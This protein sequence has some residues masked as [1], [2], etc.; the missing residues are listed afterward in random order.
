[1]IFYSILFILVIKMYILKEE[2]TVYAT[3]DN[4][5]YLYADGQLVAES[6]D[7]ESTQTAQLQHRPRVL[8]MK[9]ID[10]GGAA[11]ILLSANNGLGHR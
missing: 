10:W 4:E 11:G 1:L 7:W 3:C 6:A 8:A 2:F 9:C 5:M